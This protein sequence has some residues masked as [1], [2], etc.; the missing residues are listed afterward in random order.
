MRK[1]ITKENGAKDVSIE[2]YL[3]RYLNVAPIAL[4]IWRTVEAKHLNRVKFERPVLDIG[5]GFG[6]FAGVFFESQVEMGVDIDYKD[7][8]VAIK[9][10]K[11]KSLSRADARN[12]PFENCSFSSIISVSTLEHIIGVN[13]VFKEA[14]RVLKPGGAM[15]ITVATNKLNDYIFYGPRL[16]KVG[17]NKIGDAYIKMYNKIFKHHTLLSKKQWEK[18]V[19]DCGFNIEI[20]KEIISPKITGLFDIFLITAW[21]SQIA[22]MIFGKRFVFRPK[23]ASDFL[24]KI[25]TKYIEEEEKAGSNLLI[26]A[27]KPLN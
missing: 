25:F 20:S 27:R 10:G 7:L 17:L 13:K 15:A 18:N 21:P 4:S 16:K 9:D 3:R 6:E 19:V 22:K 14:Y 1:K 11:Y 2:V 5:C 23:F 8:I 26:V 12:L 24:V